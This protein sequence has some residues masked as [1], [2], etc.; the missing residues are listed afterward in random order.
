L[1]A[2]GPPYSINLY[3]TNI[4]TDGERDCEKDGNSNTLTN[5]DRAM[6]LTVI[7]RVELWFGFYPGGKIV[8]RQIEPITVIIITG[9]AQIKL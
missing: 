8:Q 3:E 1:P 4:Q 6:Q 5:K 7:A 2:N 9:I